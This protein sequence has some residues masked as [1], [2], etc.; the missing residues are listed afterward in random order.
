MQEEWTR[1]HPDE[2]PQPKKE[3]EE[4]QELDKIMTNEPLGYAS[5]GEQNNNEALKN[6]VSFEIVHLIGIDLFVCD[7]LVAATLLDCI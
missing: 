4:R 2:E 7:M 5:D 3:E 1:S 6:S